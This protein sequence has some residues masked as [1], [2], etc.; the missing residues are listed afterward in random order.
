MSALPPNASWPAG[1]GAPEAEP[2]APDPLLFWLTGA[3]AA[4]AGTG[5]LFSLVALL[6]TPPRTAVSLLV[7]AWAGDD[8][9]GSLSAG[10]FLLLPGPRGD[11]RAPPPLC[12]ASAALY[13]GQGLSSCLQATLLACHNLC[14]LRRAARGA[15]GP[16]R[17]GALAAALALGAAGLL[18]AALPLCGWGAFV[19]TAWGCLPGRSRSYTLLLGAV[20]AAGLAGLAG[21][22][23]P[24]A[25]RLLCAPEPTAP[26]GPYPEGARCHAVSTAQRRFSLVLALSKAAL[27]LPMMVTGSAQ[28][29]WGGIEG[30]DSN[31]R[32]LRRVP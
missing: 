22:A 4:A 26:R 29:G 21:L 2:A 11:P 25:P 31:R 8:L 6:G 3:L 9:L 7:A 12:A 10:A 28:R 15:T 20:Y 23:V 14:A 24:L 17:G 13:L 1:P 27:W 32:T 30:T 19:R 18:L 5:S 16:G